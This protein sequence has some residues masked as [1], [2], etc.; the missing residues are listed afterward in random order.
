MSITLISPE[1]LRQWMS[2]AHGRNFTLVDARP[3]ADYQQAHIPDAIWIGWEDWCEPAP[4][5]ASAELH[6]P[7]Y[8]GALE[9]AAPNEL[10]KKLERA[11]LSSDK[12][13]V[14]Y[15]DGLRSKGRE[16]RVGWMLLYYGAASVALLDGGWSGWL[17]AGGKAESARSAPAR[18]HFTVR[19]QLERRVRLSQLRQAYAT[20]K[21]PLL[22]D[23]RS[24][25][26]YDGLLHDYQPR[27]GR[28]PAALHLPYTEFFA[29][30]GN[31]VSRDQY[32]QRIPVEVRKAE[33]IVACCE[34]GVRSALF[35]LLHEYYTGQIVANFDGS[36]MEWALDQTLPMEHQDKI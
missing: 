23:A 2:D 24:R 29:E 9:E 34:V 6:Q 17:R 26:E 25:A 30:T 4:A 10:E 8:W 15:A 14:I 31:F 20:G 33:H 18:G 28:L 3:Y 13:V 5:H 19:I 11:G 35:A 1:M 7:G 32:L 27:K 36:V 22:V 16:G 21:M 12:T